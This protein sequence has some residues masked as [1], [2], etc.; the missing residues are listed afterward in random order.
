M[1][2]TRFIIFP[3]IFL[4]ITASLQA[5]QLIV[6]PEHAIRRDTV[7]PW[8][9]MFRQGL[10]FSI[11]DDTAATNIG[12]FTVLDSNADRGLYSWVESEG[13]AL[14]RAASAS[15]KISILW[16]GV[17]RVLIRA[18]DPGA[19]SATIPERYSMPAYFHE[20]P[21][22]EKRHFLSKS[23][24]NRVSFSGIQTILNAVSIDSI[25]LT[26]EHLTGLSPYEIGGVKD[27]MLTR[28]SYAPGIYKAQ[29]YLHLRLEQ[30]DY[31]VD[32]KP[33][34]LAKPVS[35]VNLNNIVAT[36]T[37]T[38]YPDEFIVLCAHYDATSSS[39]PWFRAPGADDN[40][41]GTAAVL[42]AAR[43]LKDVDTDYSIRFV[44][45][46]AEEQGLVGS[47]A[48][49]AQVFNGGDNIIGVINLDMIGYDANGDGFLEIH[50]GY[51]VPKSNDIGNALVDNIA[52]WNLTLSARHLTTN[53][54]SR[55]DHASFW[56]Y[57]IPA[58]MLIEDFTADFNPYYH[59]AA[60]LL[61]YM[62]PAYF[63]EMTKLAIG[64]AAALAGADTTQTGIDNNGTAP[65]FQDF[66]L[67][68]A[69]PNPFNPVTKISYQLAENAN[70]T[71]IVTNIVG[72]KINSL[73]Q[74][75]FQRSGYHSYFWNGMDTYGQPVTSG[76]YMII[77][78]AGME[79]QIQKM[80]LLR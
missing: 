77:L 1:K 35:M 71:L 75:E 63:Y 59:S 3:L 52:H 2:N 40:G 58:I 80:M 62:N 18:D 15:D 23:D 14:A 73:V 7:W 57:G 36:K 29:A 41:S 19:M 30:W 39:N 44:L 5:Q 21:L 25:L 13:I 20:H 69:Y 10:I 65:P 26:E 50:S 46:A 51:Q 17:N 56:S 64:S 11:V 38:V 24:F 66:T 72:Q 48:Y 6:Q 53:A 34:T 12:E 55:S 68:E 43:V 78:Q 4:M 45:F 67:F 76:V 70:V 32:L 60:D 27:S 49:A 79:R 8:Q 74:S 42:E 61:K 22:P 47:A 54:S 28:Y 33:F 9:R 31:P 37:G 16:E